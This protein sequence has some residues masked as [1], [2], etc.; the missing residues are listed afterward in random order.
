MNH[1]WYVTETL[2]RQK[3]DE[4]ERSAREAWK[5]SKATRTQSERFF[6][7]K[8]MPVTPT[9]CCATGYC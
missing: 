4:I 3:Q 2:M 8:I 1:N 9:A 5:W 6:L 7:R